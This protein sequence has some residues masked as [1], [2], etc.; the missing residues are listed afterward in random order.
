MG[1]PKP[2]TEGGGGPHLWP[3]VSRAF[4]TDCISEPPPVHRD[5]SQ[6]FRISAWSGAAVRWPS[7]GRRTAARCERLSLIPTCEKL[8]KVTSLCL[9]EYPLAPRRRNNYSQC[10]GDPLRARNCRL[11]QLHGAPFVVWRV[12]GRVGPR[13][14]NHEIR[15]ERIPHRRSTCG[16]RV[17]YIPDEGPRAGAH[18]LYPTLQPSEA[19]PRYRA[20]SA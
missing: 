12:E 10:I 9:S 5:T 17:L 15:S 3:A 14:R 18:L 19:P 16:F 7:H 8:R 2:H 4:V 1:C 13:S 6:R 20:R 11:P